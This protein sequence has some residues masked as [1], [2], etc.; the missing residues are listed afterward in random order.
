MRRLCCEWNDSRDTDTVTTHMQRI[1]LG[2]GIPTLIL[3]PDTEPMV[4]EEIDYTVEEVHY[5]NEPR[6]QER[7]R[8][9]Y[10][11]LGRPPRPPA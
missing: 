10:S 5:S 9:R 8:I 3:I 11:P 7:R 1:L 2:G 4:T 6:V